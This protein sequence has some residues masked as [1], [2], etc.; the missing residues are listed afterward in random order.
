MKEEEEIK[1]AWM[2]EIIN[3]TEHYFQSEMQQDQRASWFLATAS[4]LLT[5]LIGLQISAIERGIILPIW[6][7]A[8]ATISYLL[9]ATLS[10]FAILPLRGSGSPWNDVFGINYRSAS[11]LR[12][13][14]LIKDRF[15]NDKTWSAE[16]LEKRI[17]FHF[18]NH[19][20]RNHKKALGTVWSSIFLVIGLISSGILVI[21][22]SL[23]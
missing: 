17:K 23:Q 15:R 19:Y 14:S 11:K 8:T 4:A 5:L 13:D 2:Q 22:L 7:I 1:N 18:R 6:L 3:E 10:I 21:C 16:S 20:L 9:S 12:I